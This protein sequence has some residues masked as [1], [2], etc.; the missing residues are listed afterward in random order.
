M[1]IA[2]QITGI[3]HLGILVTDV[4]AAVQFYTEKL[5]FTLIHRKIALDPLDGALEAAFVKL[6]NMTL[7]LFKPNGKATE[8]G[9]GSVID[10]L[11]IDCGDVRWQWAQLS[12]R[13]LTLHESTRNGVVD[14]VNIGEKGVR[15]VNFNGNCGEV[16]EICE[17]CAI[18]CKGNN[19]LLGWSHLAI[20][21]SDLERSVAFY[22]K[23]GFI[24]G[25]KGYIDGA[26]GRIFIEFVNLNDFQLELIR[27]PNCSERR[28]TGAIHHFALDVRDVKQTFYALKQE[29][30]SLT[31]P[32]IKELNLFEHG[33]AYC[34]ITGPDGELIEFNQKYVWG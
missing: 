22:E 31:L 26:E 11:A 21:V 6:G 8:R 7:E 18:N 25:Q 23:L 27:R 13:G 29:G 12:A 5:G 28:Q 10:H 34:M 14:Y 4:E 33:I 1:K 15:G 2:Q 16:V 24:K 19:R 20:N 17:N 30:F 32:V 3:Q 9:G